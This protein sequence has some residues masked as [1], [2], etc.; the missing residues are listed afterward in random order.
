M[1]RP[2]IF[3]H[4]SYC[5]TIQYFNKTSDDHGETMFDTKEIHIYTKGRDETTIRDTLLHELMHVA[6]EDTFE[7]LDDMECKANDKEEHTVL[8]TTPRLMRIFTSNHDLARYIFD[9]EV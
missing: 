8:L 7:I 4:Y 3:Y 2:K 6:F 9:M 1:K 5:W